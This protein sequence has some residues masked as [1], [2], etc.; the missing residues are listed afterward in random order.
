VFGD[1]HVHTPVFV[2]RVALAGQVTVGGWL[3][4]TVTVKLQVVAVLPLASVADIVTVVTPFWKVI[5]EEFV[6]SAIGPILAGLPFGFPVNVANQLAAGQLS[7]TGSAIVYCAVHTPGAV[8]SDWLAGQI[9]VGACASSTV[10][11]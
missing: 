9:T 11:V 4:V 6:P 7:V 8:T 2:L 3:S 5:G 1:S 10:T